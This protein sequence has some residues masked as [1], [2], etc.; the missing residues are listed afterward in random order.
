MEAPLGDLFCCGWRRAKILSIPVNVNPTGGMNMYFPLP[1]R[2]HG[3]ITV[4]NR[5]PE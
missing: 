4:E 1:F 3:R 5:N 2:K